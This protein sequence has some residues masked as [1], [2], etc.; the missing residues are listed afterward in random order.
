MD[1]LNLTLL[2]L[3]KTMKKFFLYISPNKKV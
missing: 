3:P 1:Y 2:K